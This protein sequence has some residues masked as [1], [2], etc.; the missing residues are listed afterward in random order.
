MKRILLFA[1]GLL[2]ASSLFGQG[3]TEQEWNSI[4][5]EV[6]VKIQK[7]VEKRSG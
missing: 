4:P 7:L 1:C 5:P 3:L 2:L 6:R